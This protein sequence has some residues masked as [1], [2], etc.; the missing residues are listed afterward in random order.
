M[1]TAETSLN[2]LSK[3][4]GIG[5]GIGLQHAYDRERKFPQMKN[6]LLFFGPR[7]FYMNVHSSRDF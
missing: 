3:E 5:I 6:Y 4:K 1:V 2:R 7:N